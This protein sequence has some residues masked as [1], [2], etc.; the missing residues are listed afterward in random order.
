MKK[1]YATFGLFAIAAAVVFAAGSYP[2]ISQDQLK[3][4]IAEKSVVLLDAN[5]T[6][7]YKAGHIPGAID[8]AAN[9]DHLASLLPADK[10]TLVVAYCGGEKCMA[11]KAAAAAAVKLGY[12]NVRHFAPGIS[13][14]KESGQTTEPGS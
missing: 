5:G 6:D 13:G 7:S 2:D 1:L 9:Q 12:T 11:Y 3:Q 4:A 10:N 14:W 8:F